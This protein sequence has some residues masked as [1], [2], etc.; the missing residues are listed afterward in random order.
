[1][2]EFNIVDVVDISKA[3]LTGALIDRLKLVDVFPI[4]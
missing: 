4:E 3:H 1:M 2:C